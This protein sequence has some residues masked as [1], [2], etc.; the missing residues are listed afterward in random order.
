MADR[1]LFIGWDRPIPGREK[2]AA[3]MMGKSVQF[4]SKLQADG[5]I[6]SFDTVVLDANGGVLNGFIIL[7]GTS[8]QIADVRQDS[9]WN[10]LMTEGT[11]CTERVGAISGHLNEGTMNIMSTWMKLVG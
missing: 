9:A 3:E 2:Q 6:E 10:D 5:R 7:K 11:Y 1:V 8:Q 4:Y